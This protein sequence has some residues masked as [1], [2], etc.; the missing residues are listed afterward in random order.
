MPR[1]HFHI[2][3]P[4]ERIRDDE[5]IDLPDLAAARKEAIAGLRSILSHE[6]LAG[7]LSLEDRIEI[8]DGTGLLLTSIGYDE[9]ICRAV[10]LP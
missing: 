8:E 6:V 7:K 5:G 9:A 10:A 1:F 3:T 4:A 2:I